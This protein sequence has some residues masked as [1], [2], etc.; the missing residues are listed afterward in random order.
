MKCAKKLVTNLLDC[1]PVCYASEHDE[2]QQTS[3]QP[4]QDNQARQNKN[5]TDKHTTSKMKCSINGGLLKSK[6]STLE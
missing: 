6:I 4:V 1:G 2:V 3:V 5:G